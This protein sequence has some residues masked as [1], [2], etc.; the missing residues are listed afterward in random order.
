LCKNPNCKVKGMKKTGI[1]LPSVLTALN[2]AFGFF[3]IINAVKGNFSAAAWFILGGWLLDILDGRLA[4]MTGTESDFG[5]EFDSF[6]DL[7]TFGVAPAVLLWTFY[8]KDYPLGKFVCFIYVLAIAIRLA[9]FNVKV[10]AG[11]REKFFEGLPSPISGSLW[12]VLVLLMQG[13][14][15]AISFVSKSIPSWAH[16]LPVFVLIISFLMLSKIRYTKFSSFRLTGLIPF[17]VFIII[18][19][20]LIIVFIYPESAIFLI[21]LLYV[22][23]GILDVVVRFIKMRKTKGE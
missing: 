6:A 16:L 8:L 15:R 5:V 7:I 17:R 21:I 4:R 19:F 20:S 22:L 23:S 3:S 13:P 11:E 1:Y 18:V 14:K 9:R 2:L 10:S 12:A